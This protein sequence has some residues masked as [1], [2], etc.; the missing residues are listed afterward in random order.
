VGEE[1]ETVVSQ[2]PGQASGEGVPVAGKPPLSPAMGPLEWRGREQ[3]TR[4]DPQGESRGG[5]VPD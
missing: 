2:Q 3:H 4:L 5:L 1:A